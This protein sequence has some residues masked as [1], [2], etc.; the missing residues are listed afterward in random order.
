MSEESSRHFEDPW[1]AYIKLLFQDPNSAAGCLETN[2]MMCVG[3]GG[4]ESQWLQ[5]FNR[6]ITLSDKKYLSSFDIRKNQAT[7][8]SEISLKHYQ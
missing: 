5:D 3:G 7:G 8:P 2:M 4:I 1:V 6:E